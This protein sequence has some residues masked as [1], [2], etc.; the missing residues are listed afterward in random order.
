[1][2]PFRNALATV[3][4]G[5][6]L[7][8]SAAYAD[9]AVTV[10]QGIGSNWQ[11]AYNSGDAGKLADLYNQDA[12]WSRPQG[13]ARGKSE[14]ESAARAFIDAG[15][16]HNWGKLTVSPLAA[17]ENGSVIW[18]YGDFRFADGPSGHYGQVDVKEGGSWHV[19]ISVN[20]TSPK[21]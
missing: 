10:A 13:I 18:A 1:M 19:V 8:T 21:Q 20:N 2:K 6:A 9:E 15:K 17:H 11:N 16:K 5:V 12:V 4:L 3:G 7:T 14:I